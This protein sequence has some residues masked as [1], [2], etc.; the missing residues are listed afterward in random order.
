MSLTA[1]EFKNRCTV[2]DDDDS[3]GGN[4]AAAT[5]YDPEQSPRQGKFN[6]VP[7][8]HDRPATASHNRYKP[9]HDFAHIS[10][11]PFEN[12]D[13]SDGDVDYRESGRLDKQGQHEHH[14]IDSIPYEKSVPSEKTRE[15]QE[16]SSFT[17]IT[18]IED[19][20]NDKYGDVEG[21]ENDHSDHNEFPSLPAFTVKVEIRPTP[22]LGPDQY[23]V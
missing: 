22:R 5:I 15:E 11:I 21:D 16:P 7:Y 3:R 13:E 8:E 1:E 18:S 17:S 10:S 9:H 6:G 14:R 20:E 2:H 12:D 19:D 23:G 4:R